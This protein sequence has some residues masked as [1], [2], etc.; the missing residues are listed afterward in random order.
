MSRA[1]SLTTALGGTWLGRYG[2]ALCPAHED[3]NPSLSL[4]DGDGGRV[5]LKCHAGCAY[6]DI[7]GAL[8][9]GGVDRD[10]L[11]SG[12]NHDPDREARQRA[13]AEAENR[14][15]SEQAR[16]LWEAAQPISCSVAETYLR[17]RA[18]RCALPDT[19]RYVADC[20]HPTAKRLPALL[21]Y[22]TGGH[23]YAIHRTY[24]D[25]EGRG[26]APVAPAKAMLGRT[27]G[28]AVRL[29]E[30][31]DRLVIAEGVETAL[32][33]LSGL[34][35]DRPAVWA[36]LSA[37]GMG[38]LRLPER[39]GRLTIAADGDRAGREA[40]TCLAHRATHAGWRVSLLIAP[41]GK[42]WNDVLQERE[43]AL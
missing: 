43:G 40:A 37:P 2:V 31:G 8:E 24:V 21:S 1:Q 29:S 9:A 14:K 32:S 19:L 20:W 18:V 13:I 12:R 27:K 34:L 17:N 38:A 16:R 28:G 5:L 35:P 4:A 26:K 10:T 23:G 11:R 7:R 30:G 15:R 3:R 6:S 41:D 39:P 25:S 42:D 33:L 36:A 22:V